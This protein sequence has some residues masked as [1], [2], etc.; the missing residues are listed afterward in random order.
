[1][2]RSLSTPMRHPM[3][4]L[5]AAGAGLVGLAALLLAAIGGPVPIAATVGG[6]W[7]LVRDDGVRVSDG[8]YRGRFM[9]M[10]FG[11][12][13][14]PDVCPTTLATVA[15]AMDDLGDHAARVQPVFIT[16]DPHHDTPP[17]LHRYVRR[18]GP[19]LIG[20]TGTAD[21]ISV[22][23]S[24]FNIRVFPGDQPSAPIQHDAVLLLVGPNGSFLGALPVGESG[25]A[26]ATRLTGYTGIRRM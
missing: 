14:C 10:Y 4:I 17:V 13:H 16:V 8:D 6:H 19:H 25:R 11:Y 24:R 23:E 18:F 2:R 12:T 3:A 15:D 7:S 21:E 1:M 22:V 26:I 20:L 9:L 5:L